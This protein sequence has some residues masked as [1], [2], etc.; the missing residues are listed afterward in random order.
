M[1][2]LLYCNVFYMSVLVN[3]VVAHGVPVAVYVFLLGELDVN[4]YV[5]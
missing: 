1:L 5:L 3:D 2:V 4:T